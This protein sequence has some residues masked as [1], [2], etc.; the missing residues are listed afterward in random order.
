MATPILPTRVVNYSG[1]GPHVL[2]AFAQNAV[3]TVDH[4]SA[5][6]V[7]LPDESAVN[8]PVGTIIHVIQVGAGAVTVTAPGDAD[9]A[10][11]A[12]ASVSA[13]DQII[14]VKYAADTW[15]VSVQT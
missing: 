7:H 11:P 3:V 12:A 14:L 8:F 13:A 9:I 2:D 1:A 15:S 4:G 6:A 5:A 10:G